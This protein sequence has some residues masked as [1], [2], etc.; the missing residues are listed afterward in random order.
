MKIEILRQLEEN[1]ERKAF[2]LI[3]VM[4]AISIVSFLFAS[5][6][7]G[8]GQGFAIIQTA[9]ENLRATQILQER[10]ET[11]RLYT[12]DQLNTAG[13]VPGTFTATFYPVGDK[14]NQGVVYSGTLVLTNATVT[15]S[16]GSEMKAV[17]VTL[18][19]QS[20]NVARQRQMRTMVSHYGLHNYFYR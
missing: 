16:Y 17:Y 3:E 7:L 2:S 5:L 8:F 18:N 20:G 11:I 14:T 4:M 12:W 15:E 13:F 6:Y 9:R 1:A 10:M 19:W